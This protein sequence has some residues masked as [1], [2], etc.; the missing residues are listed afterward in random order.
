[1]ADILRNAAHDAY[2]AHRLTA[3]Q[4][5]ACLENIRLIEVSESRIKQSGIVLKVT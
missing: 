1:M 3:D 2:V 5:A 4:Y